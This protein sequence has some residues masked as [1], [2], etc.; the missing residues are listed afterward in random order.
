[1]PP[2]G[3]NGVSRF[4]IEFEVANFGDVEMARRSLL[5][6]QQVRRQTNRGVVG[7]GA[8]KLVLPQSVVKR[9]GLPLGDK[10][11]VRYADQR[12]AWRHETEC[13][14]VEILG[15]RDTF[16]AVVEPRR[17]TALVGAVILEA[18]DLLMDCKNQRVI[19]RYPQGPVYEIE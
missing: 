18:L 16:S 8:T 12:T 2:K 3:A 15:R 11:E 10:I 13:V 19:P 5:P 9:L 17:Q 4:S 6:P 1:M 14:R 7:S